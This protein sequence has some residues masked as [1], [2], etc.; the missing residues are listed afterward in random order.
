MSERLTEMGVE[1]QYGCKV[2]EVQT[3]MMQHR[4]P[5]QIV[6]ARITTGLL[7]PMG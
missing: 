6:K 3:K 5:L 4:P 1:V 2:V 7:V